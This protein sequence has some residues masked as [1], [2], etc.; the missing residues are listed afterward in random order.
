MVLYEVI[1]SLNG[2]I[3]KVRDTRRSSL[4]P[5][6]N[7]SE[8]SQS[9][10]SAF[11]GCGN[12][13]Q[14]CIYMKLW[15]NGVRSC[16][17]GAFPRSPQIIQ[18]RGVC[19]AAWLLILT[20]RLTNSDIGKLQSRLQSAYFLNKNKAAHH[21]VSNVVRVVLRFNTCY[22]SCYACDV[23][24]WGWSSGAISFFR[25]WGLPTIHY[26][27]SSSSHFRPL[28]LNLISS[29]LARSAWTPRWII[30]SGRSWLSLAPQRSDNRASRK[31]L[32]R[33]NPMRYRST[34]HFEDN[35]NAPDSNTPIVEPA[36]RR[37]SERK[38]PKVQGRTQPKTT[39]Y[40]ISFEGLSPYSFDST[41][42]S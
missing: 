36:S 27:S 2:N 31:R 5:Q 8:T 20:S 41:K 34:S 18:T 39:S 33:P 9:R 25:A 21:D 40:K 22:E 7:Q 16:W 35:T 12:Q 37:W 30:R 1:K 24:S 10:I 23:V 29:P 6:I 3:S 26:S 4:Q 28:D 32:S 19:H 17:H 42:T 15:L 14:A 13:Q 38:R 11:S